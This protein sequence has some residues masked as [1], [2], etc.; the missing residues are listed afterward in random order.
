MGPG[1]PTT[2]LPRLPDGSPPTARAAGPTTISVVTRTDSHDVDGSSP[3]EEQ[4]R[5]ALRNVMDPELGADIVE[6]GMVTR[7]RVDG[8]EV[9][10]EVALTIAGCPLRAQIQRDVDVHVGGA[11]RASGRS[12]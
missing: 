1:T 2:P 7:I 11:R 6:L 4:V 10:V 3:T 12:P 8:P 9:E 5:A